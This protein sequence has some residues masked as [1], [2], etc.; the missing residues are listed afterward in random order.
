MESMLV[1]HVHADAHSLYRVQYK[2]QRKL[3]KAKAQRLP[4]VEDA[5]GS[6][7]PSRDLP[8]LCQFSHAQVNINIERLVSVSIPV[9]FPVPFLFSC[10]CMII[11]VSFPFLRTQY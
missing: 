7:F 1:V 4:F 8:T 11:V 5:R 2:M 6:F 9:P 10:Q 3:G